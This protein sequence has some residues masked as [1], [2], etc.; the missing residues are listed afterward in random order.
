MSVP[1]VDV[2]AKLA[3]FNPDSNA[4]GKAI[5][6]LKGFMVKEPAVEITEDNIKLYCALKDLMPSGQN[7]RAPL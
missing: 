2:D 4:R 7:V 6:A 1:Q 3:G 5:R